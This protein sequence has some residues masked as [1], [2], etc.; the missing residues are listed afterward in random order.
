MI[1]KRFE[2][3]VLK[4]VER[5]SHKEAESCGAYPNSPIPD[6]PIILHQPKR[7]KNR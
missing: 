7:P 6:C 3:V 1:T 2:R 5:M 4:S